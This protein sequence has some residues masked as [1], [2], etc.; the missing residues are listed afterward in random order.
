MPNGDY[1][2]ATPLSASG[3]IEANIGTK[4]DIDFFQVTPVKNGILTFSFYHNFANNGS[5]G[6]DLN[7]YMKNSNGTYSAV[8]SQTVTIFLSSAESYTLRTIGAKAGTLYLIRVR[9]HQP[10]AAYNYWT[11]AQYSVSYSFTE[12]EYYEREFN[13]QLEE[14]NNLPSGMDYS[15]NLICDS[16][17]DYYSFCSSVTKEINLHFKHSYVNN[18][19]YGWSVCVFVQNADGTYTQLKSVNIFLNN[20]G[21]IAIP[22]D[23]VSG[24]FYI[25]RIE[26]YRPNSAYYYPASEQYTLNCVYKNTV[27]TYTLTYNANGGTG[28][29]AAQTGSGTI[30]L[31][32]AQP[33][34]EGY[35]FLGWSKS[36]TATTAQYASGASFSLTANTTLYAVWKAKSYT[37]YFDAQGGVCSTSSKTVTYNSTYGTLPTPTRSGYTFN[38]WYTSASGGSVITASSTVKITANQALYAHWTS[39][40]TTTYTLTYDANGGTGAPAAQTGNGKITLSSA[41]PQREGYTF[42]GWAKSNTATTAQYASGASFSLTANT[43]LYAVWQKDQTPDDPTAVPAVTIRNFVRSRTERYFTTVVFEAETKNRP[44]GASLNWYVNGNLKS[45]SVQPN[46]TLYDVFGA[47]S[48]YTVQVRLERDDEILAQSEIETVH[49]RNGFFDILFGLFRLM[50]GRPHFVVQ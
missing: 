29:P 46:V 2:T 15:G 17:K 39:I 24:S 40:P 33:Q 38:G 37:V 26:G 10:N 34:R 14:A 1:S 25:I 7:V 4:N 18:S 36:N 42:I 35:T 13:N 44:E 45:S 28:A 19:T 16:D 3:R 12:S 6:W 5:D 8:S 11:S 23:A 30:T 22:F 50:I 41:Q 49:I 47:K 27:A 31:S 21:D 32:S 43:T 20:G 9:S 48:D